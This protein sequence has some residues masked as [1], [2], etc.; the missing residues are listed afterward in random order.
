[1][2]DWIDAVAESSIINRIAAVFLVISFALPFIVAA[3]LIAHE[4][5]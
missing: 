2:A 1:M 3:L 5:G 4:I